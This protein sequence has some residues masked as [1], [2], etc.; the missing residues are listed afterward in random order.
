M[1]LSRWLE[2]GSHHP[3]LPSFP[4]LELSLLQDF[5][6]VFWRLL[7]VYGIIEVVRG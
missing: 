4:A 2:V 5:L 3:S 1:G 7:Y 6:Q